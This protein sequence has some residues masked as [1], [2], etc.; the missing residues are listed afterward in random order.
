MK[1]F[2]DIWITNVILINI[3]SVIKGV[4]MKNHPKISDA[5]WRVMQIFWQ[6]GNATAN[7]VIEKLQ[8]ESGWNP[9]TIRTMINRLAGKGA[10]GHE[11]K[12]RQYHYHP[13]IGQEECVKVETKSFFSRI[14][15]AAM[16]PMLAAFIEEQNLSQEEI[17]ELKKILDK[18]SK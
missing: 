2:L 13:L 14:S 16:K 9:K 18:K 12:G 6:T 7:E 15:K 5:E 4:D 17:E 1:I 3:T 10:I 8:D 11:I